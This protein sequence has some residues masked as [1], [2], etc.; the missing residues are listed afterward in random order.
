MW[1]VNWQ[2]S[3]GVVKGIREDIAELDVKLSLLTLGHDEQQMDAVR[4]VQRHYRRVQARR[5][6]ANRLAAAVQLQAWVRCWQRRRLWRG[7]LAAAIAIQRFVRDRTEAKQLEA[8]ALIQIVYRRYRLRRLVGISALGRGAQQQAADMWNMMLDSSLSSLFYCS[9]CGCPL[10]PRHTAP[11]RSCE[12][13]MFAEPAPFQPSSSKSIA[14]RG[15]AGLYGSLSADQESQ[16]LNVVSATVAACPNRTEAA[17]NALYFFVTHGAL[18]KPA[19]VNELLGAM[20]SVNTD[21]NGGGSDDG[22]DT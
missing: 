10:Q 11:K 2:A 6:D 21:M 5:L 7:Q 8:T 16:L 20:Q 17:K 13:C 9:C 14:D 19:W 18:A 12:V 4:L 3:V 15:A 22:D 1:T